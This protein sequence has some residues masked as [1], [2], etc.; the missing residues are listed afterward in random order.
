MIT[1]NIH[2]VLNIKICKTRSI[3]T[4]I[5]SYA[6]RDIEIKTSRGETITFALFSDN[7][8]NLNIEEKEK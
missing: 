2:D 4:E 7:I 8:E 6:T 3:E 5:G 1:T